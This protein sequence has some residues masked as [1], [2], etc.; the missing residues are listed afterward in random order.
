MELTIKPFETKHS[1][2]W[3]QCHP[4]RVPNAYPLLLC[5]LDGGDL[6]RHHRQHL[7]VNPIKLVKAGPGPGTKP[8]KA[9]G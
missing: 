7:D 2:R 8:N 1:G 6:L 9:F 4:S 5:L 3:G